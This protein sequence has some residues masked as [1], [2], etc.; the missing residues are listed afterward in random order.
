MNNRKHPAVSD[1]TLT[2]RYSRRINTNNKVEQIASLDAC[3]DDI[4]LSI[5][6]Y[7][8][9]CELLKLALT[10][11][12]FGARITASADDDN[13]RQDTCTNAIISDGS[14]AFV[15]RLSATGNK[16]SLEQSLRSCVKRDGDAISI[17]HYILVDNQYWDIESK[18]VE[19]IGNMLLD[20]I[21]LQLESRDWS[22]MEEAALQK[23][24]NLLSDSGEGCLMWKEG[25]SWMGICH[26][27][28]Q[29][30][31]LLEEAGNELEQEQ[32]LSSDETGWCKSH[33]V[34][35]SNL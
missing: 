23:S 15:A 9:S 30:L 35:V 1:T 28:E 8:T 14:R 11:K 33:L 29:E 31:E 5:A 3:V 13:E 25:E 26:Q 32:P 19:E 12:R 21:R 22:L 2:R 4:I 20:R 7:L 34:S 17:S 27:L 6:S 16:E 24:L 10:C 18:F